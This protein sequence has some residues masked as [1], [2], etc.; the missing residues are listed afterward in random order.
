ME[1]GSRPKGGREVERAST[2]T[3]RG[4]KRPAG[5]PLTSPLPTTCLWTRPGER[6]AVRP[7]L[8]VRGVILGRSPACLQ[9]LSS[10]ADDDGSLRRAEL[11]C[12]A[13]RKA[14]Q[15]IRVGTLIAVLS[16]GLRDVSKKKKTDVLCHSGTETGLFKDLY[17][18]Q[19]L[20]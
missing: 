9:S 7:P 18:C 14:S 10:S 6:R 17:T 5:A 16:V 2:L 3:F 12:R 15:L 19:N 20:N 8:L 11:L 13:E 1:T 4:G